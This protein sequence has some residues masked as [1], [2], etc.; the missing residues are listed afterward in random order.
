MG[1]PTLPTQPSIP[2][3]PG[4]QDSFGA[5][6]SGTLSNAGSDAQKMAIQIIQQATQGAQNPTQNRPQVILP[7]PRVPKQM[8]TDT[9]P[10]GMVN[11]TTR[12]GQRRND[13]QGLISSV[14]NI[15]KA[16]V[17]KQREK[18]EQS[19]MH[20]LAVIQAAASNPDD[21]HNK[22]ILDTMMNDPK[23][24]KRLQKAL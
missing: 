17:N 6:S 15:V 19:L 16:G 18:S 10:T 13:M 2:M 12:A 5:S 4:A 8:P 3:V 1:E 21:P 11:A 23:V 22:M 24:V 7:Q 14:G 20:D 9:P